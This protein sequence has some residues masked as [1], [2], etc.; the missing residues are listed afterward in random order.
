[1]LASVSIMEFWF[2]SILSCW[3]WIG[4]CGGVVGGWISVLVLSELKRSMWTATEG[5]AEVS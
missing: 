4:D 1:M 2:A 3:G 5:E